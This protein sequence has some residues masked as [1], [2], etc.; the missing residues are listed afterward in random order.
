MKKLLKK[1]KIKRILKIISDQ[2]VTAYE[3]SKDTGLNESGLGRFINGKTKS[4]HDGTLNILYNYF[5]GS[6]VEVDSAL[7][8]TLGKYSLKEVGDFVA[9]NFENVRKES[10]FFNLVMNEK[11]REDIAKH[12]QERGIKIEYVTSEE[13]SSD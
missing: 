6:E 8:K 1:E 9:E 11:K 13:S 4:P 5:F 10:E 7:P 3:L 12:L 2:D